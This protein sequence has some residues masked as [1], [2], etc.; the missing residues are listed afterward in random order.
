MKG[1]KDAARCSWLGEL[2]SQEESDEWSK[3]FDFENEVLDNIP[4]IEIISKETVEE[5]S[6]EINSDE[7]NGDM[8]MK[9]GL[10]GSSK[11]ASKYLDNIEQW[12]VLSQ[13][14]LLKKLTENLHG[15]VKSNNSTISVSGAG[16][17][18][19]ES[20]E[21]MEKD[22]LE[23]IE[24]YEDAEGVDLFDETDY[25]FNRGMVDQNNLPVDNEDKSDEEANSS[26]SSSEEALEACEGVLHNYQLAGKIKCRDNSTSEELQG[27]MTEF[28]H[29]VE[30]SGKRLFLKELNFTPGLHQDFI[31]S[32]S[33]MTMR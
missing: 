9:T 13:K 17:V 3:E 1:S 16:Y 14:I 12:S 26:W 28:S 27:M 2:D 21:N 23:I 6:K 11:E 30:S 15:K 20:N 33:P 18:E 7:E 10:S 22:G 31:T 5:E 24:N 8:N 32:Y 4:N 29:T 25:M 19:D